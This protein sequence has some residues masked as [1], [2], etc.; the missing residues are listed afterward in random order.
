MLFF[1]KNSRTIAQ[2]KSK[3]KANAHSRVFFVWRFCVSA[4]LFFSSV[5]CPFIPTALLCASKVCKG[6]RISG[7]VSVTSS[8]TSFVCRLPRCCQ[9][10]LSWTFLAHFHR[11]FSFLT[12]FRCSAQFTGIMEAKV[13]FAFFFTPESLD[14]RQKWE[15]L[16][17]EPRNIFPEIFPRGSCASAL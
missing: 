2:F 4:R 1:P 5:F 17:R 14:L 7:A 16:S 9:Q 12:L 11:K 8:T 6:K 10:L 13:L 15:N 3:Q